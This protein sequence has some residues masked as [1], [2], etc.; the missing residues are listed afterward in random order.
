M[1][2]IP[3]IT[4]YAPLDY[5]RNDGILELKTESLEEKIQAQRNRLFQHVWYHG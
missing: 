4:W 1:K 5:K 3:R 2:L